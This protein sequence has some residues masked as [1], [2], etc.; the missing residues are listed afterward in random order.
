VTSQATRTIF[1]SFRFV[2]IFAIF[3]MLE[4]I[5][6]VCMCEFEYG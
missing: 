5:H 6:Y 1:R 3:E 2:V 4:L